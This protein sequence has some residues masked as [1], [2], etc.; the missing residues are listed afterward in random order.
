[1]SAFDTS[2]ATSA[3]PTLLAV[4][5]E[6]VAYYPADGDPREIK[7]IVKRM[8]PQPLSGTIRAKT[9]VWQVIVA[10]DADLGIAS[11]AFDAN[12]DEIGFTRRVGGSESRRTAV[13]LVQ[14]NAAVLVLETR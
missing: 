3:L 13:R 10:N 2:Y 8:P 5:G 1:M 4:H 6:T 12:G 7:A 11:D 9:E 14:H